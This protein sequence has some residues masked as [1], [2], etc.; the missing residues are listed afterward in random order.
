LAGAGGGQMVRKLFIYDGIMLLFGVLMIVFGAS[1]IGSFF[2]ILSIIFFFIALYVYYQYRKATA[3]T[4]GV[5]AKALLKAKQNGTYQQL[6]KKATSGGSLD[7]RKLL[8]GNSQQ[9]SAPTAPSGQLKL[10]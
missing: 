7:F 8:Q 5:A 4:G 1:G 2:I 9:A 10:K 3:I 6:M